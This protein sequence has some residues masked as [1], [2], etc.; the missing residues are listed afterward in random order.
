MRRLATA[1]FLLTPAAALAQDD[2]QKA[3]ALV[4]PMIQ[5]IQPGAAG[6]VLTG[7]IIG[8]ATAEEIAAFAAAP[9]PSM[10]IGA[11]INGILAR[12]ATMQCLQAAAG[13]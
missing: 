1:L 12:P 11:V 9:G 4:L 13:Q 7:C 6:E 10:E 3:T 2:A 5:E 8:A